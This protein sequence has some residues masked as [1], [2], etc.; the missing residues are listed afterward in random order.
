MHLSV[1]ELLESP[2]FNKL[3]RCMDYVF[4]SADEVSFARID[5]SEYLNP[6]G[7]F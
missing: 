4:D 2:T 7:F 3:T 1:D 6:F 5:I